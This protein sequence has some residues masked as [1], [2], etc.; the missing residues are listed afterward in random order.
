MW[1]LLGQSAQDMWKTMA[2]NKT[3]RKNLAC[4]KADFGIVS[5]N[6]IKI[7]YIFIL[8]AYL[9]IYI[10]LYILYA[11]LNIHIFYLYILYILYAYLNIIYFIY[12]FYIFILYAY[13]P[14]L[15]FSVA[16]CNLFLNICFW[17]DDQ[18]ICSKHVHA[19]S[20]IRYRCWNQSFLFPFC[21][22]IIKHVF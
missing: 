7:S 20:P 16:I 15:S 14:S 5:G 10:L 11:Y 9:N 18:W 1:T 12:I 6:S 21:S 17:S 3:L 4:A 19:S 22:S 13:L 8:Q 2:I